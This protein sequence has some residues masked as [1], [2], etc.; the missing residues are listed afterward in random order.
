LLRFEA[1]AEATMLAFVPAEAASR[2]ATL[3][4]LTRVPGAPPEVL[5][6]A[7]AEGQVVTVLRL[8]E[9]SDAALGASVRLPPHAV[10]Q[11]LRSLVTNAQDA[12]P[13]DAGVVV[14]ARR[15]G[16]LLRIAI[17]DRGSMTISSSLRFHGSRPQQ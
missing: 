1:G 6:I 13:P 3:S 10:S 8:G 7:L 12:S 15:D 17:I 4:A 2:V 14:S 16:A 11:A 9:A 5:G